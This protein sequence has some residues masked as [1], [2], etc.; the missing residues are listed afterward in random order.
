MPIISVVANH[1]ATDDKRE[2]VRELT[3]TAARVMKLPPETI[4]VL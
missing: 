3:A 1:M 4:T 2:L